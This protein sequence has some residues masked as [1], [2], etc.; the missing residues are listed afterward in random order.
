MVHDKR[1]RLRST[2]FAPYFCLII[3]AICIIIFSFIQ[4]NW[5]TDTDIISFE[6]GWILA[7]GT[8]ANL[9]DI[10]DD[11]TFY[12]RLPT[13][14]HDTDMLLFRAKNIIVKTYIN[15]ELIDDYGIKED[16]G[17][18]HYKAPGTYFVKM[19][20][21][22]TYRGQAIKIE[23]ISPYKNDSSCNLK[24]LQIGDSVNL[25]HTEMLKS[26]FGFCICIIMI[27]TGVIF[28]VLS[29]ALR[30]H[31][32]NNERLAYLGMFTTDIGIWSAT[33]TMFLQLIYEHSTFWHIITGLTLTLAI[34]P[35]F[36][37]FKE[38]NDSA[39]VWPVVTIH[40]VTI[41][42]FIT[43]VYLHFMNIKDLH[44]SITLSH[45]IIICGAIFTFY[46]AIKQ[47]IMSNFKDMSFWGMIA[48]SI[49]AVADII[50]Y[51]LQYTTDHSTFTRIGVAMY[52]WF[53][54]TEILREYIKAYNSFV[55]SEIIS[56]S[57]YFDM[58]T[59]LYNRTS[60]TDDVHEI[61]AKKIYG[62]TIIVFDMNYLKYINDIY[63]HTCG[64]DAIREAADYI[65]KHFGNSGKCYRIGGDEFIYM[66]MDPKA[67]IREAKA[68][69][70]HL[71]RDLDTRNQTPPPDR[72]WPLLIA[73]GIACYTAEYAEFKDVFD[74]ADKMMYANKQALKAM[75]PEFDLRAGTSKKII[76]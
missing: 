17:S 66:N 1:N 23:V 6:D 69:M 8:P 15:D 21:N 53:L 24:H 7:D 9:T 3:A 75:H 72:P 40:I 19:Q 12:N 54:G 2:V 37:F 59:D 22:K 65:R 31:S 38:R 33:E 64:D 16:P 4:T 29:K 48:I 61:N 52:I 34:V 50:C 36:L 14:I 45:I 35:L 73:A 67:D 58:L 39:S 42:F 56:R 46:Y 20:L 10:K 11:V 74:E 49:F 63:G 76:S 51:K 30:N 5:I 62:S 60:F 25:I 70:E 44:E 18:L 55:R 32:K 27:F 41:A 28:I 68:L 57:A 47:F 43:Q 13:D 26:L 71:S